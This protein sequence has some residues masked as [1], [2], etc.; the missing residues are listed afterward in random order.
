VLRAATLHSAAPE[1]RKERKT[2]FFNVQNGPVGSGK[3]SIDL[4]WRPRA[5]DTR[6]FE[7]CEIIG[8]AE[9]TETLNCVHMIF[10][11]LPSLYFITGKHLKFTVFILESKAV[12]VHAT[13]EL[14]GRGGIASTRS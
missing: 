10:S 7:I 13:E 6:K 14:R 12:P 8:V 2:F 4:C 3:N 11:N 5:L 9:F 1:E